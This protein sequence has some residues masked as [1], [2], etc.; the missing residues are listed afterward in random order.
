MYIS[1]DFEATI[2]C[3]I[4]LNSVSVVVLSKKDFERLVSLLHFLF[5]SFYLLVKLFTLPKLIASV[6][7]G[8]QSIQRH[9]GLLLTLR[10][11]HQYSTHWLDSP[12]FWA[13]L[14]HA[15]LPLAVFSHLHLE[16][17]W[18]MTVQTKR[19]ISRMVK[20]RG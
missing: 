9:T 4:C 13:P 15:H 18:G 10:R 14:K 5:F 17:R 20:D 7:K 2:R 16:E 3:S 19:E 1:G 8:L 11:Y 6:N 12:M